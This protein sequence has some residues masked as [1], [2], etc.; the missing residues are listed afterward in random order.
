MNNCTLDFHYNLHH[1]QVKKCNITIVI[2]IICNAPPTAST[3]AFLI[4]FITELKKNLWSSY[5]SI[6]KLNKI[7]DRI[8]NKQ[9]WT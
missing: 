6:Q 5:E 8:K 1:N 2:T 9:K 4:Y 7:N 3:W